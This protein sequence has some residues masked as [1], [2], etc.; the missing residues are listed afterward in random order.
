ME[1]I[2]SLEEI[3]SVAEKVVAQNPERV[4]LFHG[5]MGAG[6]T[7]FIKALTNKLGVKGATSSPTFSLVNEYEASEN[8]LIYHFDFYRLKNETEAMDMGV[9]EYLYSGHWCF[10]E[11]AENIPNLIPEKHSV[12][13]IKTLADGKRVL[14]LQ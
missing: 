11:W 3:T 8:Q 12:I 7:T 6:K 9:D 13:T 1:F 14:E 2:F 5:D 4:I 10:I